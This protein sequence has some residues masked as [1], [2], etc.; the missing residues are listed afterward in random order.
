MSMLEHLPPGLTLREQCAD[1]K[2]FLERLFVST[3][4]TEPGFAALPQAL[5]YNFLCSQFEFQSRHYANAYAGGDFLIVEHNRCMI[6]RLYLF[7]T[8]QDI[9]VVD[10]SLA[11]AHC[12][13]GLGSL[14]L[15]AVQQLAGSEGKTVSLNVEMHNR[16]QRLYVRLGFEC[17]GQSGPYWQMVW[18][19]TAT[20]IPCIE[21]RDSVG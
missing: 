16:A 2:P 6:G 8:V 21:N 10:I 14:L 11:P 5:R 3:R 9:R 12:A 7:H 15:G 1:D 17:T 18:P 19:G 4:E 20:D 13:K